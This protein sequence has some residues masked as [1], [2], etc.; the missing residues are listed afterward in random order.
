M[1][2]HVDEGTEA[3]EPTVA[4]SKRYIIIGRMTLVEYQNNIL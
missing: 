1:A 3:P 4:Q 2:A